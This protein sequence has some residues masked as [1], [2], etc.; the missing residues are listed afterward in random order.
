MSSFT[1]T[2]VGVGPIC[3][4]DCTVLFTKHNLTVFSPEGKLILTGWREKD[5]AKLWRFD[6]RPSKEPLLNQESNRTTSLAYSAYYLPSVEALVMYMYA[7]SGVPVKSTW[8]RA[9]K[10]GN[11]ETWPGLTYS[12]PSKY[13]PQEVGTMKGHMVK[14]SQGVISTRN[15]TPPPIS[16]KS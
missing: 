7:E 3:D 9:I 15:N 12:N 6:L 5:M 10:R 2:I 4:A 8:I 16:I 13:C 1:K 11:F 14:S